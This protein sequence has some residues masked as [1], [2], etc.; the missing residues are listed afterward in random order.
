MPR[1]IQSRLSI[2]LCLIAIIVATGCEDTVTPKPDT[3]Q[4]KA[5][6]QAE[7]TIEE[8]KPA[9]PDTQVPNAF[10]VN[11]PP[12]GRPAS[13]TDHVPTY[14]DEQV[15]FEMVLIPGDD[16]ENIKPFY[17]AKT[18]VT[19]EMFLYWAY[20]DDIENRN[21]I[22]QLQAQG[23]RPS[24][25]AHGHPQTDQGMV[26][27]PR[28]PATG[29]SW[30]VAQAYCRWVSEQTGRTY[31]LPTD[32]EWMYL[33]KQA[34][35]IPND[36]LVLFDRAL[37]L[38]N[39]EEMD[40]VPFLHMPR[41]VAQGEPDAL[42]LYD[43]LGNAAEWVQPMGGKRWVRG[44]HFLTKA[45]DLSNHWLAFEDQKTWNETYPQIPVSDSWYIDEY[46]Q[47]IR[48]VCSIEVERAE[49]PKQSKYD[50]SQYPETFTDQV[51]G[52]QDKQ[53]PFDM[54]LI[55]GDAS[56]EIKPFYI[57][58][59]EVSRRMFLRWSYGDDLE[60]R[61]TF[62]EL[63]SKDLRPSVI[64]GEHIAMRV[65]RDRPDW[66]DIPALGMS[67]LTAQAYCIWLSEQTGKTYRLPTDEEWM[68]VLQLSGGVPQN[69]EN[70][71]AQALLDENA[72]LD[73]LEYKQPRR[74]DEGQP[75]TLGLINLLGNAT[76]WVQ[77]TETGR[78]VRG[79]H[80]ELKADD[81]T[82]DWRAV[83]D[84]EVWNAHYPDLPLSKYWYLD[85][86]YTGL[87]LVCEV[88]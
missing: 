15:P 78:W 45:E 25:L 5:E 74:V 48:L 31:R 70:L 9:A 44:G 50:A 34:G 13:F 73:V 2:S 19:W 53:V 1:L 88:E 86:Y 62:N 39:N 27:N 33:F 40:D 83:E 71:L 8:N 12:E 61:E 67:W 21:D 3:S 64:F 35:G 36:H 32:N 63:Q 81:L 59:T 30:R 6:A 87:R 79:G 41:P 37:L 16:A 60:K 51:Q 43:L 22:H 49:P 75:N 20:C 80:F 10:V 54:V 69:R 58:K 55:P 23:L 24:G 72:E 42:G 11:P 29:M 66:L 82:Q 52:Y 47:G 56:K 57:G 14:D 85:F 68:H 4:K 65:A 46:F 18:E 84:N 76:E 17:V 38:D 7:V 26:T 77:P 28:W